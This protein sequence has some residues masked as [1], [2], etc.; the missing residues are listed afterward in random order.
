MHEC[1]RPHLIACRDFGEPHHAYVSVNLSRTFLVEALAAYY[2]AKRDAHDG[3]HVLHVKTFHD[4]VLEFARTH[5]YGLEELDSARVLQWYLTTDEVRLAPDFL[6]YN[7]NND[8]SSA[9]LN[10]NMNPTK[11]TRG[12]VLRAVYRERD[13]TKLDVDDEASWGYSTQYYRDSVGRNQTPYVPQYGDSRSALAGPA[14]NAHK[15]I[16]KWGENDKHAG[17]TF[18]QAKDEAAEIRE[19]MGMDLPAGARRLPSVDVGQDECSLPPA[20]SE[21]A[22][23]HKAMAEF[24]DDRDRQA[25]LTFLQHRGYRRPLRRQGCKGQ[26]HSATRGGR[27]DEATENDADHHSGGQH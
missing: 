26:G 14:P 18:E 15:I 1:K 2:R 11:A 4:R 21:P 19:R 12:D 22:C 23:L 5:L 6:D 25:L 17:K 27:A 20:P 10:I 24:N 16:P 8:S 13:Y 9:W 7:L 3:R